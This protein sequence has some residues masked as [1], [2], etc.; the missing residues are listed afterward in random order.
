V[1]TLAV[2]LLAG[3]AR[4]DDVELRGKAIEAAPP[5]PTQHATLRLY[6]PVGEELVV[7]GERAPVRRGRKS[8]KVGAKS[9]KRKGGVVKVGRARVH[10]RPRGEDWEYAAVDARRFELERVVFEIVDADANGRFELG[11]DAYRVPPSPFAL[12]LG[13]RMVLGRHALAIAKLAPDGARLEGRAT[14]LPGSR[15]QID[16]LLRINELRLGIGLPPTIIDAELSKGATSHARYLRLNKWG[17]GRFNPHGE[18]KGR[19]GFSEAGHRAGLNGVIAPS[20]HASGVPAYWETYYHR[21]PFLHPVLKG[22][23]ISDGT[24]SIS[25]IDA[26]AGAD[27]SD[28]ARAAWKSPIVAPADGSTGVPTGF[29][30]GGE[31]PEPCDN[32]GV[33][34]YP[35]TVLFPDRKSGVSGFTGELYRLGRKGATRVKTIEPKS[36]GWGQ[37]FGLIPERPLRSGHRYRAVYRFTRNGAK[38]TVTAEFETR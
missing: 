16:G 19:R 36:S 20:D 7:G 37:R 15:H 5:F 9:V 33:R 11:K 18:V 10:V 14:P 24:P 28:A 21:F 3:L 8:V 34:G 4:A 25:V 2:V 35:L 38:E 31:R 1:R 23:G 13:D 30:R 32:P 12:P 6:H 22:V 29:F 26:K 17:L 27:W